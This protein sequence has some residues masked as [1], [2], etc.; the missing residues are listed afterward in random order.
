MVF[1]HIIMNKYNKLLVHAF[2]EI[3][4]YAPTTNYY[5]IK[6]NKYIW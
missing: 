3:I 4:I 1:I 5:P 2:I 6:F